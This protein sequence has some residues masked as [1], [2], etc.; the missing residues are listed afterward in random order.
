VPTAL[1][2]GVAGQDGAYLSTLLRE[3]GYHVFGLV[4][5][6]ALIARE[7]RPYL[8]DVE[9]LRGDLRDDASLRMAI[10]SC[11]PDEVY[12]LAGISSVAQ[13]WREP[14]LTADVNGTGVLRLLNAVV[15][16]CEHT[17]RRPRLLQ[18]S[19]SEIFGLPAT[20]PQT[21]ETPLRPRNPY[22][23][24]KTFAHHTVS[25]F[26]ESHGVYASTAILYNHESPLRPP[27]FVTRKITQ[28]VAAISLGLTDRL[29]LGDTSL[30]RD[31]GG[32]SDYVRAMW[33]ALQADAP[34]DF[35]VATGRTHSI[36]DFVAAAF[37]V[38]GIDDWQSLL[39]SDP[40]LT[41]PTEPG[42]VVGDATRAR[43]VLGWTATLQ[44]EGLVTQMV[45][46]DLELLAA[47]SAR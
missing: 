31:W 29:E 23:V 6:G 22:A 28:T 1:I 3:H 17:G 5:P 20:S 13:A 38:V 46:H 34:G 42:A 35:V 19:S 32:A 45:Q 33:L 8:V 12:N 36:L 7:L 18:A 40:A 44:F 16:H 25:M 10:D 2:T 41:R 37:E 15:A 21:E 43:E 4:Q 24:A 14:V 11:R 9:I 39:T 30:R 26:R 47:R 27:A